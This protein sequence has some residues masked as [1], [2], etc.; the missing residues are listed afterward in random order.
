MGN[1]KKKSKA[2]SNGNRSRNG[3]A[4]VATAAVG[5]RVE[6]SATGAPDHN[7]RT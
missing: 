2:S 7:Q 5:R 4:L 6:R 1:N 3:N